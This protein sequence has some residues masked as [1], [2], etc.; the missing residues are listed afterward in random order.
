VRFGGE[1]LQ[2]LAG[3]PGVWDS[4][5]LFLDFGL[6]GEVPIAEDGGSRLRNVLRRQ[7][8]G[9]QR[10]KQKKCKRPGNRHERSLF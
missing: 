7:R 1:N 8:T 3:Q 5:E 10:E 9:H 6:G 4:K 2:I